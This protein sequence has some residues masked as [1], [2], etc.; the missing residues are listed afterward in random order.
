[1]SSQLPFI[2]PASVPRW[3]LADCRAEGGCWTNIIIAA[4]IIKAVRIGGQPAEEKP[5][6]EI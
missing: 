4:I 6:L 5:G 3:P 2:L 1:M